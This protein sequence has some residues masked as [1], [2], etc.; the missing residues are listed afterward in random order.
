MTAEEQPCVQQQQENQNQTIAN[1]LSLISTLFRC[2][3]LLLDLLFVLVPVTAIHNFHFS[4]KS[5]LLSV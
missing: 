5:I 4:T 1:T 3:K 2:S